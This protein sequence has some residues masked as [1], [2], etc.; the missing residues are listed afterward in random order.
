MCLSV[1]EVEFRR[2]RCLLP[3]FFLSGHLCCQK[4]HCGQTT[5]MLRVALHIDQ[6]Q[7]YAGPKA[8][9]LFSAI[10]QQA[11]LCCASLQLQIHRQIRPTALNCHQHCFLTSSLLVSTCFHWNQGA[12]VLCLFASI[13]TSISVSFCLCLLLSVSVL[14]SY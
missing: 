12:A 6:V 10:R 9:A 1:I 2:I 13:S 5:S 11:S 4:M 14:L 7:Y 8:W 3:L